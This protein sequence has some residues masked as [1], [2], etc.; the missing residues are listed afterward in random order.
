MGEVDASNGYEG[1]AEAFARLEPGLEVQHLVLKA[2][3]QRQGSKQAQQTGSAGG[4]G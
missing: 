2:R 1:V 4:E 3:G